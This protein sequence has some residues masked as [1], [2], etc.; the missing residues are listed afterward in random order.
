MKLVHNYWGVFLSLLITGFPFTFLL[1]LS[2]ITG[3]DPALEQAGRDARRRSA[4]ALPARAAAAAPAGARDHL[5]P[6]LRAGLLGVPLRGAARRA[7]R[8]DAGDLDRR[9]PGRLRGIRLLPGLRDRDDHGRS[10]SSPSW[11]RSWAPAASSI[12]A[13]WPARRAE[14]MIRDTTFG[15]Q[16]L[17]RR[18]LDAG[19]LLHPQPVRDDRHG[20]DVAPSRRAG[21]APGCPPAGRRAGTPPPG[22]SSSSTT[23]SRSPSRSSSWW[24]S[25]P[26][27]IGVPAAYALARRDF[28]G[29]RL[30]MLLFLLPLLVP[31]ITFGIP[32]ATVLYRAGLA[33]SM[34]GVVLANLVPTV[35]FVILVMIP[36][37]EQ[38]DPKIEAAA[39]VFG[40]NTLAPL[41]AR[42]A[43]AAPARHAG[44][45]DARAGAH[46]RD[47]RAHL[48]DR[49]PDE[50][51]PRRRALL[52]GL[53][54]GRARRAVDRR[55][56]GDLHGDDARLAR[57]R[58][59]LRQPDPDRRPRQAGA[60][61]IDPALARGPRH[62]A[63][64]GRAPR[65]RPRGDADRR[66]PSRHRR[67]PPG[68]PGGLSRRPPRGRRAR[69]GDLR[70]EPALPR[71][72]R[73]ARPPGRALHAG[74][75]LRRRRAA[76]RRR[77]PC[78]SSSSRPRIPRRCSRR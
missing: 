51:D 67:L 27:L 61:P 63:G 23:C 45:A 17:G 38:I 1:T 76:P 72:P 69:L 8:P 36:F 65:L 50:P 57:H 28:P 59:A 68:A 2:Y 75:P 42:P 32:L 46:H 44:G 70:R 35:P 41:P 64:G 22:T 34:S 24:C 54:G 53:R 66:R 12:A 25:C 3:V 18:D 77:A 26:G 52:R 10:C 16:A 14:P 6:V 37:I 31:P 40:A 5:L 19:R 43:A 47:V 13:P 20:G 39:R 4:P 62:P 7:R 33:G 30:V 11:W 48:P 49:R 73:R 58:A 29:K 55:H 74:G 60:R 56:G 15:R 78:A 71:H 9:L 21:S